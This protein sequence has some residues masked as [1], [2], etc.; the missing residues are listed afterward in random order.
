MKKIL[1]VEDN[2]DSSEILGLFVTKLGHQ[3]IKAGNSQ[4]AITY[5]E[6]ECPDLIFMDLD[7]PDSDGIKTTAILKKN[8]KTSHIPVVAVTAWISALWEE[9]ALRVGIE[10]YLI[11]PVSP[12][13]LKE[14]IEEYTKRS[15]SRG[16]IQLAFCLS[17][18]LGLAAVGQAEDYYMYHDPGGKLVISNKK[19]PPGSKIIKQLPGVRDSETPQSQQP[20]TQPNGQMEGSPKPSKNG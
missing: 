10:T 14:T 2:K 3:V 16:K 4:E 11:K 5:T 1:I 15:V 9:K 13:T 12:Q 19:P 8:P 7:L 17:L 18:F 6:A 20:K